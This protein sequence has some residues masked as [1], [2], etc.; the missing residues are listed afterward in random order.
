MTTSRIPNSL[1][2]VAGVHHVACGLSLRGLIALPTIR[3]SAGIDIIVATLDG[4]KHA[5]IQVKTSQ[6]RV[7][8]WPTPPS[9]VIRANP[10]DYYVF[11]R[12]LPKEKKFEGYMLTGKEAKA[13]VRWHEALQRR[14]IQDGIQK[15][16]V[17]PYVSLNRVR[18][19]QSGKRVLR[20]KAGEWKQ[21]WETWGLA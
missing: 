11:L 7:H 12:W 21:R 13:E 5:N 18:K 16:A 17:L 14:K 1:A 9:G 6:R 15:C 2:G 19:T 8:F 10:M 20:A 3:N 4:N